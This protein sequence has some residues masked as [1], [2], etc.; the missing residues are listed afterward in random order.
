MT[1]KANKQFVLAGLIAVLLAVA[2]AQISHQ[3]D[4]GIARIAIGFLGFA[5]F[6]LLVVLGV[7]PWV[8]NIAL[9][10]PIHNTQ[11]YLDDYAAEPEKEGD[12]YWSQ[13]WRR[14]RERASLRNLKAFGLYIEPDEKG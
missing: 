7:A 4:S 3:T 13:G 5:A 10:H 6:I 1:R 11:G 2:V 9:K 8:G 14:K 12:R